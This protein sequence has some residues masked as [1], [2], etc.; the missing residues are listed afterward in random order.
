[1][2][3]KILIIA[4]ALLLCLSLCACGNTRTS[5]N[6]D[7]GMTNKSGMNGSTERVPD[8]K[9][10]YVGELKA[11]FKLY[12]RPTAK[13]TV[14]NVEN[15]I[16]I[17]WDPVEGATGY[18]IYRR[19]WSSTTNGWT[20]F[21]RWF[22]TTETEWMDG[23]DDAHQVY[24]GTRY[25]YGVKAYFGPRYDPVAEKD[26]GGVTDNYN[27]GVVGPLMTT[28]R[29]TTRKLTSLTPGRKTI[30]AKWEGSV[31]ST[32]YQLQCSE[33]ETFP[34]GSVKTVWIKDPAV[35]EHL[36]MQLKD[37]THYYVRVRSYQLFEG[38]TYFGE[39]SNVLD[40][41]TD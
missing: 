13:T 14:E 15:G 28:V 17:R 25:Q 30:L 23:S 7:Y 1:M 34:I 19:A 16:M 35:Y 5:Y 40:C 8:A 20:T 11:F 21:E 27:L 24:A 37:C 31:N 38:M 18:V 29:I 33:D 4:L 22:N 41:D 2:K 10:G 36:L 26:I 6:K 9:D 3:R 32:G 39:W 12:L